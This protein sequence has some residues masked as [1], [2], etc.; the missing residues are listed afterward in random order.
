[1]RRQA[2]DVQ[3]AILPADTHPTS[4][5]AMRAGARFLIDLL[6]DTKGRAR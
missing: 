1:M 2:I 4:D 3:A 5:M 6:V